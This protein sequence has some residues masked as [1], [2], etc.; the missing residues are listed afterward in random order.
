MADY[1]NDIDKYLKGELTPAEMHALEKKALNDPFLADALE[2][3]QPLQAEDLVAD[4][5]QLRHSVHK[6]IQKKNAGSW[7]WIGRIAAGLVLL[8]V[9]TYLIV[10]ISNRSDEKASDNLALN[11]QKEL[12]PAPQV[13][14]LPSSTRDSSDSQSGDAF[15]SKTPGREELKKEKSIPSERPS[16]ARSRADESLAEI[17]SEKPLVNETDEVEEERTSIQ[18]ERIQTED[19]LALDEPEE[20]QPSSTGEESKSKKNELLEEDLS[21][22]ARKKSV[23]GAPARTPSDTDNVTRRIVRGKV[24]F[25]DDGT[26]LPGVNV[27][28]QGTNEGTVT[29]VQ[30]YYQ[31]PVNE[32]EP[33]L[34]FSFIGFTNKEAKADKDEVNVQLDA[35]VSELSEVV[36]VGYG[37]KDIEFLPSAPTVMELATPEGGRK[38]FKQYL[39]KNVRYPEQALKNKVE[40]KV[41]IQFTIGTSGQLSD[42]RVLR[43]IGYGCDEEVIRLIKEGPKWYPTKKNE[44]PIRDRVRVRMRFALPKK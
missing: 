2:G 44:A 40:G 10:T 3:V 1:K 16:G 7:L 19:K 9:S 38:V 30:G 17:P 11:K 37:S 31:I 29:D 35:D 27:L 25:S 39:E 6:R 36:V 4:L 43:G 21:N 32:A 23:V 18:T 34:L 13:K 33:T 20:V 24:S 12:I 5:N 15:S 8:A 41:T 28:I 42:F 14:D 26:G 22:V